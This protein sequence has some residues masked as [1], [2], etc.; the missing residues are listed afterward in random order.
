MAKKKKRKS[1]S[2]KEQAVM[3]W[4]KGEDMERV[5]REARY[6]LHKLVPWRDRVMLGGH[7]KTSSLTSGMFSIPTYSKGTSRLL[8]D[9][10]T[11]LCMVLG[12]R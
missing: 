8:L 9:K 12:V 3:R 7:V 5:S 1:V 11:V 2:I 10:E 6:P 4:F